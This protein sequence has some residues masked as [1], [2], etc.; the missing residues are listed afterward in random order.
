MLKTI[1]H[2]AS[3]DRKLIRKNLKKI[4]TGTFIQCL[5]YKCP[6]TVNQSLTERNEY[7]II[8]IFMLLYYIILYY[9]I[10]EAQSQSQM[11]CLSP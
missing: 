4:K 8:F 1:Q 3:I 10:T 2:T 11:V 6:F 7:Y 5:K 9:I